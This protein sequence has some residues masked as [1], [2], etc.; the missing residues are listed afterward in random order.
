MVDRS[1]IRPHMEVRGPDGTTLGRVDDLDGERIKLTRNDSPDR[2]H[3]Y[4]PLSAVERVDEHVHVNQS[5]ETIY[6]ATSA[7]G[8]STS[9]ASTAAS[10]DAGNGPLPPVLNRQVEGARPRGNYYLPWIV[11][12]IG[13]LLLLLLLTRCLGDRDRSEVV[14]PPVATETMTGTTTNATEVV[15]ATPTAGVSA[16]GG[17]LGRTEA[18]PRTF[19]FEKL[20]FDTAK[21]TIRSD[22]EAEIRAIAATLKQYANARVRVIGYADARGSAPANAQLGQARA[23]SVKAALVAQGIA[24]D[25]IETGSGGESAPVN[26]NASAGGQAEN[27]RTELV[28]LA[29]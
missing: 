24:G 12:A 26:S 16:L 11:G 13:L 4:V 5:R 6:G 28:V 20:N 9:T 22:D 1:T 10:G 3:H 15:A 8:T 27:R 23:D 19:T 18:A 21:S 14:T 17:Y 7:A 29:R 25:R 2:E